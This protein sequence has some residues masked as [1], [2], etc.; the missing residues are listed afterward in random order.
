[1]ITPPPPQGDA[2]D[3]AFSASALQEEILIRLYY[4]VSDDQPVRAILRLR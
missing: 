3:I 4:T 1:V 2:T